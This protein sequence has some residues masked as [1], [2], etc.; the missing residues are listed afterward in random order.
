ML[1]IKGFKYLLCHIGY[2][3]DRSHMPIESALHRAYKRIA[4]DYLKE[5]DFAPEEIQ[6]EYTVEYPANGKMRYIVDV[7]G[8][9]KTYRVAIECGQTELSK[10][11]NLRKIFDNVVWINAKFVIDQYDSWRNR[12]YVENESLRRKNNELTNSTEYVINKANVDYERLR[13]EKEEVEK[14]KISME[15]QLRKLQKVISEAW[16]N[17]PKGQS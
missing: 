17:Q 13:L 7:V 5:L 16:E 2:R 15:I 10:L 14:K 8:I 11:T 1:A 12:Y 3:S 6:E 4:I 9:K